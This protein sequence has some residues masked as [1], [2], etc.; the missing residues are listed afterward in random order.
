MEPPPRP[1]RKP[2]QAESPTTDRMRSIRGS[3][4]KPWLVA[5]GE[6]RS[7]WGGASGGLAV[8]VFLGLAGFFFYNGAVDYVS[9]ALLAAARGRALDASVAFFSQGLSYIALVLMLVAPII[10]MRSLAS[11]RRGG[12]LDF[13]QTLPLSGLQIILGHYLAALISVSILIALSLAPF[14]ALLPADVGNWRVL[15]CAAAGLLALVKD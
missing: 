1:G 13:F 12:R 10:T 15:L 11:G 14:A 2:K 9:N 5:M 7:F 3:R 8:I 6:V 4:A